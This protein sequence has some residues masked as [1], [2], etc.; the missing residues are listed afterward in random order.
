VSAEE[1][2]TSLFCSPDTESGNNN[3][4]KE[5]KRKRMFL[6]QTVVVPNLIPTLERQSQEDL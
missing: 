4:N 5:L 1:M 2:K 3:Y 6:N